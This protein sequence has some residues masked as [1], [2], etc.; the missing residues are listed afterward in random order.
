M[1]FYS[2]PDKNKDINAEEKFIELNKAYDV[3]L[4]ILIVSLI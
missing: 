1:Y 2:H 3:S 4:A